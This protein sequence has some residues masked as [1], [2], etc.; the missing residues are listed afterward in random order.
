M[1]V[2]MLQ[3]PNSS[4]HW[5]VLQQFGL[6]RRFTGTNPSSATTVLDITGSRVQ[7]LAE[8]SRSARHG[9]PSQLSH[10]SARVH[11]LHRP[12]HWWV[13]SSA[14]TATVDGKRRRDDRCRPPSRILLTINK[15]FD[16]HNG[17]DIAFGP[18]G[19]LYLGTGDGG[20][21]GDPNENGQRLTTL[22][23]KMLRIQIGAPGAAYTIP[24]DNPFAGKAQCP[25]GGSRP[26]GNCP[27]IYAWGLRNPWRWSFDRSNGTLWVADVGQGAYEEVNTI[28]R[29][30]NYGW[31]C[32]EGAHDHETAGC[33]ASGLIDPVAEYGR[34]LGESITGG[35]RVSRL[36]AH[37]TGRAVPVRR[38]RIRTHLGLDPGPGQPILTRADAAAADQSQH[39]LVRPGQ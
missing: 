3:A 22:L 8:R 16:N 28:Q 30:G 10:R 37:D 39:L 5:Y 34:S 1:P 17:G 36:A 15:P 23:G 24:A 31:D 2:K 4:Q 13:V 12:R 11:L 18:D 27:E 26:S 7:R 21:G 25:A 32:R 19:Y 6:V 29:G 14:F 38:F 33:P 20:G 35:F 9:V